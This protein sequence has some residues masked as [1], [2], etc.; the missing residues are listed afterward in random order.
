MKNLLALFISLTLSALLLSGCGAKTLPLNAPDY[1]LDPETGKTSRG[2]AVGDTAEAF[3][4]AYGD[5]RIFTSVEDG[6]YQALEEDEIPFDSSITTLLPTFFID[7]QPIDTDRFCKE[8]E[9]AKTDLLAF[10]SS[11][12]YLQSHTVVYY[13]L[14]FTWEN[15]AITDIQSEYMDYNEDATLNSQP[16]N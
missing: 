4:T 16:A 6:E 2:I 10:L 1:K 12:A 14:A 7:G 11:E 15:G 3:L 9:I 8:N 5:Y 13:Y